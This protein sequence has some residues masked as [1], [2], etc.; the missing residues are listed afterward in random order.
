MYMDS[1]QANNLGTAKFVNDYFRTTNNLYPSQ[2]K[3]PQCRASIDGFPIRLL[4]NGEDK[5]IYMFNIDR[6]AINNMGFA[7]EPLIVSYEIGVNSETG[8]GAFAD[9]SWE[10]IRNE[11]ELRY[12][13]A[14]DSSVVCETIGA[15]ENAREVLKAGYHNDLQDMVTWVCNS[16]IEEFRS[17]LKEHFSLNHLIDYYLI[18]YFL[19]LVDRK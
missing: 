5:G 13:Y 2:I 10:S 18:V 15:G 7:N 11:F 12:H 3:N 8:A 16:S 14:G 19:G 9:D 4:I 1:S 6:Y 17:G